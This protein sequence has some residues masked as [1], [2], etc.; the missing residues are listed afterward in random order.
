[1]RTSEKKS[2]RELERALKTLGEEARHVCL[3]AGLE[4]FH[5][6]AIP[7][8]FWLASDV[9]NKTFEQPYGGHSFFSS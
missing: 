3:H 2:P 5:V 8:E 6:R 4:Q 7:Q 9:L 1:M